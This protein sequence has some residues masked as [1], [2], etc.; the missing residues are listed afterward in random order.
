MKVSKPVLIFAIVAVLFLV[1][2][3][4]FTGG[5]KTPV[6]AK[7][8]GGSAA[9][10]GA[11]PPGSPP[12]ETP[13]VPAVVAKMLEAK[14]NFGKLQLAW[15]RDPF[16]LPG[17]MAAVSAQKALVPDRLVAIIENDK[18]RFAVIGNEVVT[19]GGHVGG[20]RVVEINRDSVVLDR[21]GSRITL[22]LDKTGGADFP[23]TK[24]EARR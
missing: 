1:Y 3:V 18:G 8:A 19:R 23:I 15:K 11:A 5:K 9:P 2:I 12:G 21:E 17:G 20:A 6:P 22:L 24:R 7:V 10:S 14:P 16:Q 13:A 4:F